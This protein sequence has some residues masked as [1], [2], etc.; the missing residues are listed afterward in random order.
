[1]KLHLNWIQCDLFGLQL[2]YGQLRFSLCWRRE[3]IHCVFHTTFSKWH[4]KRKK[5]MSMRCNDGTVRGSCCGRGKHQVIKIARLM[6]R[7]L[8]NIDARKR[9]VNAK[10]FRC[11]FAFSFFSSVCRVQCDRTAWENSQTNDEARKCLCERV[12]L[13]QVFASVSILLLIC[14][15]V[16][17]KA[18]FFNYWNWINVDHTGHW[19]RTTSNKNSFKQP[20]EK[21][22]NANHS[23]RQILRMR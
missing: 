8:D 13:Y 23:F 19:H 12:C 4:E 15:R 9:S 21:E 10:H 16:S 11:S 18:N 6:I 20:K 7:Y 5:I 1:M 22:W 2:I 3:L 14:Y 17:D